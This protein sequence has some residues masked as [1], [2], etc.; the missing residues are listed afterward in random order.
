MNEE[1]TS[2]NSLCGT[3]GKTIFKEAEEKKTDG[4]K[5]KGGAEKRLCWV[6]QSL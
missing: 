4:D 3:I 2:I 6:L 1:L 5:I